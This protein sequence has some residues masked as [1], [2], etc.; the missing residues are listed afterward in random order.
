MRV[1]KETI[2]VD[3][4]EHGFL[5]RT[6]LID[7][8]T[9]SGSTEREAIANLNWSVRM[10]LRMARTTGAE[11]P[12]AFRV[13]TRRRALLVA[14]FLLLAAALPILVRELWWLLC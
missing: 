8:P 11:V 13:S 5:A 14:L 2:T 6:S 1:P 10:Y 4:A 9:G 7:G 3:K 12:D